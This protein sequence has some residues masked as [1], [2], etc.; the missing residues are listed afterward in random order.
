MAFQEARLPPNR[1]I[2]S[3]KTRCALR[4]GSQN[5][6]G[7][8]TGVALLLRQRVTHCTPH[9]RLLRANNMSLPTAVEVEGAG[10]GEEM[11]TQGHGS[12]DGQAGGDPSVTAA[13]VAK[14]CSS[15]DAPKLPAPSSSSILPYRDKYD[16][17]LPQR[18]PDQHAS[19]R[20]R[21]ATAP[22]D[23][24]IPNA[25]PSSRHSGLSSDL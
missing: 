23:R 21:C 13:A 5:C 22:T 24:S 10:E 25:G 9:C 8:I 3:I 19:P 7:V 18:Q 15:N 20:S 4:R 14:C 17:R 16:H 1:T 11:Q 6:A 2:Q 12:R